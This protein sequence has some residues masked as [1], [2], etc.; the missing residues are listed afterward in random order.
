M[1]SRNLITGE[2]LCRTTEKGFDIYKNGGW[3]KHLELEQNERIKER[4]RENKKDEILDLDI[5]L[6][7][8]ES[9]IG[10]KLILAGFA[11]TLLSFFSNYWHS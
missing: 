1:A 4:E 5:Q 10:K 11:I 2:T 9:K 6:K 8:F 7:R 3:L